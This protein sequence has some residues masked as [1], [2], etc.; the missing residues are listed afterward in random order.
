MVKAQVPHDELE[1][2]ETLRNYEVLDT[3][4]EPAFER[5]VRLTSRVFGVPMAMISLI[6][7]QRQWTKARVG[8]PVLDERRDLSFCGHAILR[9]D[10]MVVLDAS[11]D[12]RFSDNPLVTGA[13]QI[14]FYAGAP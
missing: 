12:W 8:V 3:A 9:D 2:L 5:L 13:P 6:D 11:Q 1:R 7:Q 14:R 4:S 10:V